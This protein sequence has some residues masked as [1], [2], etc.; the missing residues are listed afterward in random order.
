MST[1][2]KVTRVKSC[3]FGESV[4]EMASHDDIGVLVRY[5]LAL[6]ESAIRQD[7]KSLLKLYMYIS[8]QNYVLCRLFRGS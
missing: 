8:T 1:S 2:G 3:T 7:E 4:R 6:G 5:S